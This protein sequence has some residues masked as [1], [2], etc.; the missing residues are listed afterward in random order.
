MVVPLSSR[1]SDTTSFHGTL[2]LVENCGLGAKISTRARVSARSLSLE[3]VCGP[4]A[5]YVPVEAEA[6]GTNEQVTL[7]LR[8]SSV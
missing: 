6:G 3:G 7:S 2:A 8:S 4:R 1:W 5:L